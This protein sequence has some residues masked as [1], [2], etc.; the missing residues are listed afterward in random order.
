MK[1]RIVPEIAI[2]L[3]GLLGPLRSTQAT[4]LALEGNWAKGAITNFVM[5]A[6]LIPPYRTPV[7]QVEPDFP[8]GTL[9]SPVP[10]WIADE[11]QYLREEPFDLRLLHISFRRHYL[12]LL[13]LSKTNPPQDLTRVKQEFDED[14]ANHEALLEGHAKETFVWPADEAARNQMRQDRDLWEAALN[15]CLHDAELFRAKYDELTH[16]APH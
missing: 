7:P 6:G 12:E 13:D 2:I 8:G 5:G 1:K 10:G 9:S 16:F 4:T 15:R 11:A 3:F 14:Y